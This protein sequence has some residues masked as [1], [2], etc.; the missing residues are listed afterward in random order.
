MIRRNSPKRELIL[1]VLKEEH[2]ALS[3][4]QIHKKLPEVDLTTIYRN[5]ELFLATGIVKE[6]HLGSGEALYEYAEKSHHHAICT[7]CNKVL[8]FSVPEAEIKK[9]VKLK[10]FDLDTVELTVRGK[11]K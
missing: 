10:D 8:H 11:C 7:D 9:L 4:G 1:Q 3:A 5:L 2:D 6:L